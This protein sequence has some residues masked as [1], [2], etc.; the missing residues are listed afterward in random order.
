MRP[1]PEPDESSPHPL[2]LFILYILILSSHLH[3]VYQKYKMYTNEG[4]FSY[5]KKGD[6]HMNTDRTVLSMLF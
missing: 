3:L 5:R 1:Y 6:L 2:T 4:I